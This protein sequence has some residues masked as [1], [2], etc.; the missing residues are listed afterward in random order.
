MSANIIERLRS[1]EPLPVCPFDRLSPH[2]WTMPDDKPCPICGQENTSEGPDKC[3]GADT[4]VMKEAADA[5]ERLTAEAAGWKKAYEEA[6][7]L[8]ALALT[9]KDS[10]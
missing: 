6:R 2:Y 10:Q 4:R 7:D 3:R 5:I 1:N 9:S 8:A